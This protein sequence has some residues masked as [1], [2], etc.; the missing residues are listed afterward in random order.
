MAAANSLALPSSEK[1]ELENDGSVRGINYEYR[2]IGDPETVAHTIKRVITE[3]FQI[4]ESAECD[5]T[6]NNMPSNY[7]TRAGQKPRELSN[8]DF[9]IEF[10]G[11]NYVY[12][13]EQKTKV[14]LIPK[15][16]AVEKPV[17]LD[18]KILYTD[19]RTLDP[20]DVKRIRS[21]K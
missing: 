9:V 16:M 2:V 21:S 15:D 7:S 18:S 3:T 13:G 11:G 10:A 8:E 17:T 20:A 4:D 12:M 19:V 1:S 14:F 5:F 6:F